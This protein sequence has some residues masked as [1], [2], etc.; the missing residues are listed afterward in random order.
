MEALLGAAP[1]SIVILHMNHPEGETAE[2]VMAAVPELKNR[3]FEFV[4]FGDHPL[5]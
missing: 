3:G 4:R 1:G 2:G 5:K